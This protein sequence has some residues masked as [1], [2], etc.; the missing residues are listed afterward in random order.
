M[1]STAYAPKAVS[2]LMRI[3]LPRFTGMYAFFDVIV[4]NL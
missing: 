3:A 1:M 4:N 2:I